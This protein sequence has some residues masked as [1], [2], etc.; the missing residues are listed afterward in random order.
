M[1]ELT[2]EEMGQVDGGVVPAMA[3]G[4]TIG[5]I[6]GAISGYG[7]GGVPGAITGFALGSVTGMFLGVGAAARG[8][9][10]GMFTAYSTATYLLNDQ[11]M[12]GYRQQKDS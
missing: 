9:A 10:R 4:V 2:Y 3:Y 7:A 12:D 1:R 11:A 8:I 5:G 6:H